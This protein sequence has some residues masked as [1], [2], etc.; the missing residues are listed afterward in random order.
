LLEARDVFFGAGAPNM[1]AKAHLDAIAS[2]I[3]DHLGL[4]VER[5][6]AVLNQRMVEVRVE[7][8]GKGR[9]KVVHAGHVTLAARDARGLAL[10]QTRP[11]AMH[12]PVAN[13]IA[14]I[15]GAVALS[16]PVL[17]AG[18]TGTG[19]TSVVSHLAT[20]L[21]R[22]LTSLN[23]SHQ[24]EASDLVGGFRPIDARVPGGAMQERFIE[25]FGRS[26]SRKKNVRFEE[27]ARKAVAETNW[28]RACVLWKEAAKMARERFRAKT[29]ER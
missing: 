20:L 11:F 23:M 14:R 7:K 9:T 5:R 27:A 19:K 6:D 10:P 2:V 3:G 22:P 17:L 13:L 29:Q 16:E 8:D 24:T 18:E 25:L 21:N 12:R 1:A 26:F 15:A 4:E 28:K